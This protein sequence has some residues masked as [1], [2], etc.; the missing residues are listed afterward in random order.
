MTR[1]A[2]DT[3][4]PFGKTLSLGLLVGAC[5]LL[6]CSGVGTRAQNN[7]ASASAQ[8]RQLFSS[9]ATLTDKQGK[10]QEVRAT[11]SRWIIPPH[12]SVAEFPEHA[13]L[14][15]QSRGGRVVTVIDGKEEKRAHGDYW[16]VPAGAKMSIQCVGEACTLDVMTLSLP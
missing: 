7:E 16:V 10:A 4:F 13:F 6:V 14:L 5:L 1:L 2:S 11:V 8:P 9:N 3:H 15:I 12:K